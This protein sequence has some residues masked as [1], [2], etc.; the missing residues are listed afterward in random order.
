MTEPTDAR[1]ID[2]RPIDVV[3]T[4]HLRG[5]RVTPADL[6]RFRGIWQDPEVGATLGGI[7]TDEQV[8]TAVARI[9]AHWDREGWGV[10]WFSRRDDGTDVGYGGLAP[11]AVGGPGSVEVLYAVL[12]AAWG[13]GL[14]TE[15]AE[16]AVNAAVSGLGLGDRLVCFTLTSNLASQRV[17]EKVGFV[18]DGDVEHAGLPHVLYRLPA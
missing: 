10:W 9:A 3:L 6:E 18:R 1:P 16:A 13:Q 14:A 11:T 8:R 17:M 12:P 2:A 4:E 7:R 15:M 5:E